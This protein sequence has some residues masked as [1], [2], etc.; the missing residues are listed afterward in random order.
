MNLESFHINLRISKI[1]ELSNSIVVQ[2]REL[3][4]S[5]GVLSKSIRAL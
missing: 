1:R 5:I 2:I 3:S 4:N